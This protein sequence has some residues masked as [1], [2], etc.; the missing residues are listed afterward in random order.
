MSGL[1]RTFPNGKKNHV[2]QTSWRW[3]S[4]RPTLAPYLA[5]AL[6]WAWFCWPWLTGSVTI[7]WDAKAQFAPQV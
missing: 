6:F 2:A 5:F 3:Q 4:L 7:P 1:N